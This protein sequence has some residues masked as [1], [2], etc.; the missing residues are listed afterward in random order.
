M[1]STEISVFPCEI[2]N[3]IWHYE[4]SHR[5]VPI[6]EDIKLHG[7]SYTPS[8]DLPCSC[9]SHLKELRRVTEWYKNRGKFISSTV[10]GHFIGGSWDIMVAIQ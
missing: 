10:C 3:I 6:L 4:H 7:R 5:S 2:Q 8:R 1:T 9:V